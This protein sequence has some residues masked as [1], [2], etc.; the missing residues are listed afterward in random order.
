[1]AAVEHS[2]GGAGRDRDSQEVKSTPGFKA[3]RPMELGRTLVRCFIRSE[4]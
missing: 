1:M 2:T 4:V 3:V